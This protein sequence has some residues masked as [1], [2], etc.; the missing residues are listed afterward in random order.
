MRARALYTAADLAF[1]LDDTERTE[2]LGRESLLIFRE[3]GDKADMADGL[4]LLGTNDW[5]GGRYMLARP[6]LEEAAS[7]Y[8][9]VGEKWKRGRCLTQLARISTM[10]GEYEQ[11]Q[12]LLEQS[13]AIYRALGDKE[14]LGW[15]L[16]LLARLLFFSERDIAAA[17]SLIEQSLIFLQEFDNPWERAYPL[18][19]LGQ[20]TL[21]QG[22]QTQA[23]DL[24]E[25]SRS[26]FK[27]VGDHA[28]MAEALM[29]LASVAT[30]QGNFVAARNL[31]EESFK[32]LQRIQYKELIP[33][34]LEGL[35]ALAAESGTNPPLQPAF[36]STTSRPGAMQGA[37]GL[38][39]AAHLWGAEEAL[40]EV[41][42][43]PIPV[44][45]QLDHERAVAKAQAQLGNEAFARAWAEGRTMTPEQVM[46]R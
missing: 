27:E 23:R 38:I 11:A 33:S 24:F 1:L 10:Q 34:C 18:V 8:Q 21:R 7:L 41:M 39:W 29:G 35:A 25:E 31:Y 3:L 16:Y 43:T 28:G 42:G 32:I 40:R 36:A 20:H 2:K 44:V 12:G 5:A 17:S 22:N 4:F 15:A 9:E 45:Y 46:T 30:T 37:G 19:L 13:L 6:Q 14:R 26:S